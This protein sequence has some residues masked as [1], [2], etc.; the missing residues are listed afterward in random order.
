MSK[1]RLT[2]AC[3]DYDLLR[4]L[5]DGTVVPKG[6]ELTLA[7]LPSPQRHW[8]MLRHEE[9]D[10]CELSMASYLADR[11]T[12]ERFIAIPVFPHRRFRHSYIFVNVEAKI[13]RPADLKGRH[14]G[15]RTFQTTAGVWARGILQHDYDV[16]LRTIEWLTQDEEDLPLRAAEHFRLHRVPA[17][18]D[19][20]L[21]LVHGELDAVIYPEVL[22]SFR[23][24]HPVVARLFPD[25]KTEE[26]AYFQR[27]GIF[28]IMHTVAFQRRVV[29][30]DPW[31]AVNIMEA[32][33]ASKAECYRQL[34]DPRRISLAWVMHLLEEQEREMGPD[35]W[36]YGLEPNREALQAILRYADEQSITSRPLT[37]E[38]L[39]V[40]ST[41]DRAPKY[42]E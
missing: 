26:M 22:P 6:I 16:D 38:D 11:S 30:Q 29:E 34:R 9:F 3:G 14:I 28:P 1:L 4:P 40:P 24:G 23:A 8:R 21:M 27:T 32:F 37:A 13:H 10:V 35:P 36:A 5:I 12:R 18:K 17:G 39:F 33:E 15:L 41:L 31:I 25:Y 19:V 20:D 42:V 7:T 2:L